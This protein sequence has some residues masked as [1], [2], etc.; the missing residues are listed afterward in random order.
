M[1]VGGD[2]LFHG[3]GS[4]RGQTISRRWEWA[5]IDYFTVMGVGRAR[6]FHGDGSRRGETVP[7]PRV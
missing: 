5:G 2:R 6:L 1:G 4:G 3:D 7:Q